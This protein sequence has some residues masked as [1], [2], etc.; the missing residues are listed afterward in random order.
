MGLNQLANSV[1]VSSS[2]SNLGGTKKKFADPE[3]DLDFTH[4]DS[5]AEGTA[6]APKIHSPPAKITRLRLTNEIVDLVLDF[7]SPITHA[8][9]RAG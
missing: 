7:A 4:M 2:A 3:L 9:R 6:T 1:S 8:T 5:C